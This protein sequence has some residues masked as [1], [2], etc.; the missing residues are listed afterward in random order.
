MRVFL[1]L[2]LPLRRFW[3]LCRSCRVLNEQRGAEAMRERRVKRRAVVHRPGFCR[4]SPLTRSG[5]AEAGARPA[6]TQQS[7]GTISS[8]AHERGR[9]RKELMS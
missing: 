1:H 9:R 3:E 6:D 7:L 4:M 2:R 8:A 5:R